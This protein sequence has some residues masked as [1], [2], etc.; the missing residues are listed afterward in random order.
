LRILHF[1]DAHIGVESYGRP[2]TEADVAEAGDVGLAP[3]LPS[4]QRIRTYTGLST[5]L[6]DFLAALDQVVTYAIDN[7]VD[8]ALFCG[9]AYKSRDPSQT[10]QREF[11]RRIAR[12]ARAGIPAFLLV[13]NHDQPHSLGR[14]TALDIFPTLGVPQV[15]VG[16]RVDVY[17]VETRSG[18]LQ[19]LAVPWV[20][21]GAF[22]ASD[23]LRG[24]THEEVTRYVQDRLTELVQQA[25]QRLD[26]S[27]PA[28]VAGHVTVFGGLGGSEQSMT[29]GRDHVLPPSALALP[30]VDYVA[31]GH[32]HRHQVIRS[33]GAPIVYSGSTQRVDFGE[34]TEDKGFCLVDVSPFPRREGG[35]GVRW[36]FISL[37]A[38]PFVTVDVEL[39]ANDSDPTD[40]VLAAIQRKH[41]AKAV[42]RVQIKGP[43]EAMRRLSDRTIREALATA[44][45]VAGI[46]RNVQRET[47]AR[48]GVPAS[49]LTP[50][51]ALRRYLETRQGVSDATRARALEAGRE[52]VRQET[53]EARE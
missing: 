1:A 7:Q 4:E 38:R 19:V 46:A 36:D 26:P 13:G 29:L 27:L 5:R 45:H 44:H 50:E 52:L 48:L 17:R 8:L 14:A 6:L 49:S 25:A 53:A 21:R 10:Q 11:A 24:A 20:R 18:P 43:Q 40:S 16:D 35:Q 39:Q 42:V 37:P 9:D 34:E 22:T 12:L 23:D 41:I 2:A 28:V 30:G 15:V 31:L 51:E 33:G 3:D 47:P 32:L